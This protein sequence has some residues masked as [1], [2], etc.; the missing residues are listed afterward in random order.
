MIGTSAIRERFTAAERDLKEPFRRLLAAA[1]AKIGGIAAV[2]R[3]TG[4]ARSM[5]GRRR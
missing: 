2:S 1:D 3:V 4:I 5:I